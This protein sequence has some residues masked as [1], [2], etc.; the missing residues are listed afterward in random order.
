[1][2]I[3]EM[4]R[5]DGIVLPDPSVRGRTSPLPARLLL[6]GVALLAIAGIIWRRAEMIDAART[7]RDVD[8]R[9]VLA[10][11]MLLTL[12]LLNRGALHCAAH[13]A[14][15][16]T[17]GLGSMVRLGA[18]VAAVNKVVRSGGAIGVALFVGDGYRHGRPA[19]RVVV[20][21]LLSSLASQLALAALLGPA[22]LIAHHTGQISDIWLVGGIGVLVY[23]LILLAAAFGAARS[24]AVL[25]RLN[26]LV[27]RVDASDHET[28]QTH[29][30][31]NLAALI[32]QHPAQMGRLVL[33]GLLDKLVGLATL[34]VTLVGLGATFEP[35]VSLVAYCVALVSS[36]VALVPAGIGAVEVS[37]GA[38]LASADVPTPVINS[39]VLAFRFFDLWM[40]VL[41]GVPTLRAL[42]R[43]TMDHRTGSPLPSG[44]GPR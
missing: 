13:G 24:T 1:M 44:T 8:P 25:G 30:P 37:L 27:R 29:E 41:V 39:G 42:H 28:S 11:T 43:R 5:A 22:V 32:R 34:T 14:L 12:G 3:A 19:D 36:M 2:A 31:L 23:T 40:P 7:I 33:H 20:A 9:S 10:A 26:R 38:A 18:A 16:M 4:V 35:D 17:V 15:G 21:Y 6:A